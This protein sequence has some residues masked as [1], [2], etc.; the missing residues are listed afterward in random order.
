MTK[1]EALQILGLTGTVSQADIKRAYQR[2][3]RQ[4]H[5]D[6][7]PAGI[8]IIKMINMADELVKNEDH[9]LVYDNVPLADYPETLAHALNVEI[10]WL[11]L[12]TP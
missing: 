7:N 10:C 8:E 9:L 3:A 1:F 2:K 4:Y 12:V 5:P 6:R 11:L